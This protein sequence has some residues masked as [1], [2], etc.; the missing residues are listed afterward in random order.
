MSLPSLYRKIIPE[1]IRLAIRGNLYTT[2]IEE[3]HI[4]CLD[5]SIDVMIEWSNKNPNARLM[6]TPQFPSRSKELLDNTSNSVGLHV[7][8]D[9]WT[10]QEGDYFL[11]S[12]NIHERH[13]A[14]GHWKYDWDIL[15]E[16]SAFGY[17]FIHMKCS[18]IHEMVYGLPPGLT[19]IPVH[20]HLHDYDILRIP[21][22]L[23]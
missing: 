11:R 21:P 9:L 1:R 10:I 6:L 17:V 13:F 3:V 7:H 14:A 22:T 20:R 16:C 5:K 8:T 23:L 4:E 19:L 2:P 15:K 12:L 18:I